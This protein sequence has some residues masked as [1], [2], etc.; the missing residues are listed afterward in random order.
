MFV[1]FAGK[2]QPK[3]VGKLP[4]IWKKNQV[5]SDYTSKKF[6]KMHKF[7][8][9]ES[10]FRTSSLGLGVFDEVSVSKFWPGLGLGLEGYSLDYI[11][12]S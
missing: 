1:V 3:H 8:S 10:R 9:L 4:E 12:V 11:T 7:W 2:K 6:G 5:R